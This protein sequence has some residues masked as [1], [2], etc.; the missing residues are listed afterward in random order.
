[1]WSM[2]AVRKS[3]QRGA[4]PHS[5]RSHNLCVPIA[6]F[7][8]LLTGCG[9]LDSR[10]A[11]GSAI[12]KSKLQAPS[13][14]RLVA[15]KGLWSGTDSKG[16]PAHIARIEFDAQNGFGAM[17]RGCYYAS[18]YEDGSAV[19]WNEYGLTDCMHM[20]DEDAVALMKQANFGLDAPK[21]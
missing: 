17:I 21:G 1:M 2:D 15:G 9:Q 19:R 10:V 5:W 11:N 6:L 18:W 13:S 14:F 4:R 7:L 16:R 20:T 12:V 3:R 8:I